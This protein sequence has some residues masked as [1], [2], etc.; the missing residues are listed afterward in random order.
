MSPTS[1]QTAPP[2]MQI[3]IEAIQINNSFSVGRRMDLRMAP[4]LIAENGVSSEWGASGR[5]R[6]GRPC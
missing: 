2:R 4:G 3:I 5:S 6:L 1:Y